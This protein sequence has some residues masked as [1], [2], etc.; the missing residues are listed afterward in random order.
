MLIDY[1]KLLK[2]E[3][4]KDAVKTKKIC[5]FLG[6]GVGFNIGMPDWQ[7]LAEKIVKFS[8]KYGIIKRSEKIDLL[9]INNPLKVIS[10]CIEM[11][12]NFNKED[13]FNEF[14]IDLFYKKPK[15]EFQKSKIYKNLIKLYKEKRVL[16]VQTN[17]DVMIEKEQSKEEG[18]N[19]NYIIPFLSEK[20]LDEKFL[21]TKKIMNSII[22]LHGRLSGDKSE[23]KKSSYKD[24]ILNKR[25]Y[26]EIY[27]LENRNE[28]I[29]QKEFIK[30]L[31]KNFYII[32][33][34]YSLNDTEILN[35]IANKPETENYTGIRVI[36]DNCKAKELENEFSSNYISMAS[37]DNIQTYVYN[38][39]KN[40]IE[41]GFETL[42]NDLTNSIIEVSNEKPC[43]IK[44]T[45]PEDVD[46]G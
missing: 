7:G 44:Y 42:I 5:L 6:S 2:E 46:F 30:F 36:V 26:N 8:L 9:R 31:L 29:R 11:I 12:E 39:E 21:D 34:G 45:N 10:I 38:T 25:Q 40:G 35:L 4:F 18:E 19:R 3:A 27:I 43:L 33:L 32:F 13:I 37:G 23:L 17:Y 28:Y 41:K 22:Y 1:K 16:I 15:K 24:L 14:L 20:I